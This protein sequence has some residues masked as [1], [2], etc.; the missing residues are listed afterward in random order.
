[1]H[2]A[3]APIEDDSSDAE[4]PSP[5]LKARSEE[6]RQPK[7]R[8]GKKRKADIRRMGDEE[9]EKDGTKVPAEKK[10]RRNSAKSAE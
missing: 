2:R 1:L 7:M 9:A 4:M 5:F 3:S 8:S 10:S 6:R